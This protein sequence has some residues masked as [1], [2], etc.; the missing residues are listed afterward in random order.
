M[1]SA[2]L[3]LFMYTGNTSRCSLNPVNTETNKHD[4]GYFMGN[5]IYD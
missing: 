2:K 4:I 5:N 3:I 1:R